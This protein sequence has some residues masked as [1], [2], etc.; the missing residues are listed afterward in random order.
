[1][2]EADTI[3]TLHDEW[4]RDTLAP[5]D[6]RAD[7]LEDCLGEV[8]EQARL[9]LRLRYTDGLACGEVAARL[10]LNLDAVYKRL[11]RLHLTLRQCVE[12]KLA[13]EVSS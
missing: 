1:M 11:S 4:A 7:A 6:Q 8:P 12:G 10:G 3:A 9:L 2:L 5:T 13:L